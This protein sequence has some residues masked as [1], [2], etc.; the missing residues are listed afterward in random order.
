MKKRINCE[1][2]GGKIVKKEVDFSLYGTSL[3]KFP[4]QVCTKCGE[5][6]FEEKTSDKID[7]VAKAKGLWGLGA[8]SKVGIAGDSFIIRV[9]KKLAEFLDLKKGEEVFLRPESKNKLIVEV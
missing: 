8:K 2:C 1:E 6:C 4:A 5:E 9:N 7:Q 3:G